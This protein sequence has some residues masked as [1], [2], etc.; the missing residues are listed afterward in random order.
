MFN[1]LCDFE[2]YNSSMNVSNRKPLCE[3]IPIGWTICKSDTHM[4]FPTQ[5]PIESRTRFYK[6]TQIALIRRLRTFSAKLHTHHHPKHEIVD[7]SLVRACRLRNIDICARYGIVSG[8]YWMLN[9]WISHWL[10]WRRLPEY[11]CLSL[12]QIMIQIV[13]YLLKVNL[14]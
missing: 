7:V 6:V 13:L 1:I 2:F 12:A 5:T 8:E 10:Y 11:W 9:E 14:K 3:P 4:V